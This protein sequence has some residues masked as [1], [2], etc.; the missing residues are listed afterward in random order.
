MRRKPLS[1]EIREEIRKSGRSG[2]D[3]AREM[4]V[5]HSTIWRFANGKNG[6]SL[7]LLDRLADVLDLHAVVGRRGKGG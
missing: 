2:Y 1:D 7:A 6:L 5:S 4:G 3:I